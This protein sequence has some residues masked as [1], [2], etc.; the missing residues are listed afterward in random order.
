MGREFA[1]AAARWLHLADLGVRPELVARLRRRTPTCSRWYERLDAAAAA[2]RRLPR[3]ARRRRDVEAV[4]CAVPHHLHAELYVGDPRGGQA[5]ARRE[6]VRDRPRRERARSSRAIASAPGAAR[7]LLVGAAVLPGRPGG[8]RAGSPSGAS[9]RVLEVR[10]QFLHSSDLDPSKPINWKRHRARSTA[11]TAAWATSACTRCT[12]RC[13]RAG[14]RATCAR[15][16]RDVV[17]ERPGRRT[18]GRSPCDTLGQRAC[19]CARP[20]R[21]RHVPAADRDEADRARARRTRG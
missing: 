15:S 4:Y 13:A 10:S 16:S 8:R 19:S 5:P 21:R 18:A 7:P 6:A 12:C 9:G 11:S 14:C 3:A 2:R 17:T 20:T 1:S